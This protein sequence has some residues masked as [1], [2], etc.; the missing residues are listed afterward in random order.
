M[1]AEDMEWWQWLDYILKTCNDP[2]YDNYEAV[3]G[4][5]GGE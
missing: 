5:V 2:D 3:Q 1:N 4:D